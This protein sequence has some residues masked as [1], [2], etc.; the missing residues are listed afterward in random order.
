MLW[1]FSINS[2]KRISL[3][4]FK[5][6]DGIK[7]GRLLKM[8]EQHDKSLPLDSF[9]AF[10]ELLRDDKTLGSSIRSFHSRSGYFSIP[11][12]TAKWH[13]SRRS[14]SQGKLTACL[15]S[16]GARKVPSRTTTSL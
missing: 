15:G 9:A 2:G 7:L 14:A 11:S 1:A 13:L 4:S 3:A 6:A 12:F 16:S 5:S 10:G 8:I